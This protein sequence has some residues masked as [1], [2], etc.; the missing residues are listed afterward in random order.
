MDILAEIA[1]V[2]ELEARTLTRLREG[3]GPS[4]EEAVRLIYACPGK[5]ILTGMGKSG[6]IAQKIA[7]T[8]VSTGTPA[9]FM[10]PAEGMHGDIGIAHKDD[11]IIAISKS[12]ESDELIGLLPTVRRIGAR[13]IT[14]TTKPQ[15]TI[16]RNSDIVLATPIEEEACPL[17]MAPTCSTT[18]ALVV[19]DALAMALMKL[20][21]FQPE[22]FALYHPGGQLGKRLLLTVSD[23]MRSGEANPII[24]VTAGLSNMLCEI[25][26]KRAG[27]VSVVDDD[28]HLLGLVTDY[29]I[30]RVLEKGG[31]IL[32]MT[33]PEIMNKK[34]TF[35]YVDEKAIRALEIMENRE[36][37]FLVLPVLD[38]R[39]KVV[40][41]I[42]LH[43]LVARGL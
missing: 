21:N 1:R 3:V 32:A 19:G 35:V 14:I 40:G 4:Y 2:M 20:R 28:H 26:S 11:V 37:P 13:L 12:G 8:M 5:V 17:N 9:M 29:D 6:S 18:A 24:G 16:A 36:K 33:V 7:S 34:P 38:R 23:I 43:D 10:H 22:D 41:M 31:D 25:T 42:H 30:R 15:S 27:A 39:E